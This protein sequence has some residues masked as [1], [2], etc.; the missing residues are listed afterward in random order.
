MLRA[1][2]HA[3]DEER[4]DQEPEAGAR[5]GQAVAGAGKRGAERE[6]RGRTQAFGDEP[7]GNLQ[8]GHGAG[9]QRAQQPELGIAEPELLLPDR[10]HDIDQVG[11][12]VVQR[13]RTAG[14]AGGAA[15]VALDREQPAASSTGSLATL[16]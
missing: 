9:E 2:A 8:A 3:A 4:D 14:D 6:H 1:R 12:A 11:I 13:M 15:L 5:A 7:G 10:Q 16:M